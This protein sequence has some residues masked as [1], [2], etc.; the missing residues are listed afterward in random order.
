M[1]NKNPLEYRNSFQQVEKNVSGLIFG[2]IIEDPDF[3]LSLPIYGAGK[4]LI[5]TLDNISNLDKAGLK[6]QILISDN[7]TYLNNEK[8]KDVIS[9]IMK[10]KL[11]NIAYFLSEK[12]LGQYN[13]FNR[14]I[15][16][17]KTK[18]VGMLH[19]DDF[20]V[21]D[22]FYF[23]KKL[24]P[25]LK[26]HPNIGMVHERHKVF[27][28]DTTIENRSNTFLKMY[29]IRNNTISLNGYSGTAFPTCGNIVNKDAFVAAGGYNDNFPSSGDA[30]LSCLMMQKGYT[31]YQSRVQ[32]GWYRIANNTSA[33]LGI[34]KEF[35]VE[36]ELFRDSWTKNHF[37]AKI[38]LSQIRR[39]LYSDNIA[40]KVLSF[41][42]QNP[43]ITIKALDYKNDYKTYGKF[44]FQRL[45]RKFF[46]VITKAN[47]FISQ[48]NL[49]KIK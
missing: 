6:I 41:S 17:A 26:K 32:T 15:T 13:N 22:Y 49:G 5:K 11:Q 30:F 34:C 1:E 35:I 2:R 48:I 4:F 12:P 20:L 28:N 7:K 42:K 19:D 40:S 46:I 36:D 9:I 14:C 44:A 24:L 43:E 39:L 33:N 8:G 47:N 16:L 25:F 23:I 31:I 45:L 27:S 38:T 10:S 18:Y 29:R 37:L 21:P 3:T